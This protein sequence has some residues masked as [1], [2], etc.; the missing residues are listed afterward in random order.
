MKNKI[1]KKNKSID[2]RNAT[3]P[4][5]EDGKAGFKSATPKGHYGA[6]YQNIKDNII[7]RIETSEWMPRT[8]IPSEHQIADRYGVSRGTAHRALR[9]LTMEG[10]L[11]GHQGIGRFVAEAKQKAPLLEVKPISQEIAEHGETHSANVHLL[12]QEDATPELAMDFGV[13]AAFPLFRSIIVHKANDYPVQLADR[14]VNPQFA[15]DYLRQDFTAITP[16]E[17]LFQLGPLTEVEHIIEAVLPD[18]DIQTLLKMDASEPC[19]LIH[20]RTWSNAIIVT[21]ARLIY[22]GSRFRLGGRFKPISPGKPLVA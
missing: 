2:D 20:R 3:A 11:V 13:K 15:P 17:Y 12:V 10:Y 19:I 7:T 4:L 5:T 16:S 18:N 9:E 1:I 14:Y 6:P 22:P 21:K 8:R